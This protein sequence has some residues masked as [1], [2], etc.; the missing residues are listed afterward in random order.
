[1][2]SSN[3]SLP[4]NMKFGDAQII[5]IV[6]YSF[7]FI[8]GLSTNCPS[9]YTMLWERIM[10]RDRNRMSLLLIHL[11]V[12][13]L[14]VRKVV[15]LIRS[16]FLVRTKKSFRQKNYFKKI[17]YLNFN[18]FKTRKKFHKISKDCP[19]INKNSPGLEKNSNFFLLYQT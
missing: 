5:S 15:D 10:K 1:M 13:D 2:V 4:D 9:L 7:M 16:K 17:F 6:A 8:I 14:L 19:P 18:F 3:F 11:S 12:A